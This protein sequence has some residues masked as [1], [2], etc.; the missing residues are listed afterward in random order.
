VAE[1]ASDGN[2][3]MEI[4]GATIGI[5]VGLAI[6]AV[7]LWEFPKFRQDALRSPGIVIM[8]F[9]VLGGWVGY[10]IFSLLFHG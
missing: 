6:L 7:A 3:V 9:A 1:R 4:Y 5:V 8:V 2:G 10:Q